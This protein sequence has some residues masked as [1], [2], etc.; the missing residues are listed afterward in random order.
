MN[1]SAI[2]GSQAMDSMD[3]QLP[4]REF[5]SLQAARKTP[6]V[7][8]WFR[9]V[10]SQS[11]CV[12]WQFGNLSAKESEADL[13]LGDRLCVPRQG[14]QLDDNAQHEVHG[15]RAVA[16]M[17]SAVEC[18][19]RLGVLALWQNCKANGIGFEAFVADCAV[20]ACRRGC[21]VQGSFDCDATSFSKDAGDPVDAS[22]LLNMKLVLLLV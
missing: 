5:P 15:E 11:N 17:V 19:P 10:S 8:T 2:I 1:S 22:V 3:S 14:S 12:I 20:V 4:E 7:A 21:I 6:L 16:Q 13:L 9:M 18:H